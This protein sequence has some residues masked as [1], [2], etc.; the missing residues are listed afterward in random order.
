MNG[1]RIGAVGLAISPVVFCLARGVPVIIEGLR[2][3]RED[4][5]TI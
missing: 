4:L 5:R 3:F 2:Y 1:V